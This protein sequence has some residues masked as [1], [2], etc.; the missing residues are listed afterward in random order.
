[1]TR[2]ATCSCGQLR[3]TT[4]GEPLRVSICHC[5]E[6][7][8]RTGSVFSSQA[9]FRREQVTIVGGSSSW[10]RQAESGNTLTFQFCPTCGS[11][12]FWLNDGLPDIVMVAIGAFAD[13]DFPAPG[14]AVW[15]SCRH[16]WVVLPEGTP[17]RREPKQG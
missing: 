11:T 16:P 12:V 9:R 8:R 5:H 7:Q 14:I 10:V 2:E 6:C 3:V 13:R 15:D 17:V 4:E 1:M